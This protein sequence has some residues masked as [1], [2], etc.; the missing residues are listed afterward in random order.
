MAKII[1]SG[2]IQD[3]N[4]SSGATTFGKWKG[5]HWMRLKAAS[6]S[7]P[8]TLAQ[9]KV[10]GALSDSSRSW[11]ALTPAQRDLWNEYADKKGSA[12]DSDNQEGYG[13]LIPKPGKLLSGFNAYIGVNQVLTSIGVAR[14]LQPPI[15]NGPNACVLDTVKFIAGPKLSIKAI[16]NGNLT[17]DSYIQF[18]VNP[19]GGSTHGYVAGI[20]AVQ[21]SGAP[22]NYTLELD[23]VKIG[24]DKN[25][26]VVVWSDFLGDIA[27]GPNANRYVVEVQARLIDKFGEVGTPSSIQAVLYTVV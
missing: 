18:W 25:I 24:H 5:I 1:L 16:T 19:I 14:V 3:M 23:T 7:N 4:G 13:G 27:T 12:Q 22:A 2:L 6:I 20:S 11:W 8:M 21:V 15:A 10:R 17:Q 9:S 26:G